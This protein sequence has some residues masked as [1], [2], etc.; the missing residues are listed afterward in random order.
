MSSTS[1]PTEALKTASGHNE[2]DSDNSGDDLE[3]CVQFFCRST[4]TAVALALEIPCPRRLP[5]PRQMDTTDRELGPKLARLT[6]RFSPTWG[7]EEE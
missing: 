5:R 3:S 2:S 6:P 1:A 4:T 7:T